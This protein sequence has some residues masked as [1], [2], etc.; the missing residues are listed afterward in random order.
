M[1]PGDSKLHENVFIIFSQLLSS[2]A[3]GP[4]MPVSGFEPLIIGL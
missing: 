1:A 3:I 4:M 2:I